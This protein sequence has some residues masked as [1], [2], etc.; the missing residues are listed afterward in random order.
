MAKRA[1]FMILRATV[2][3]ALGGAVWGCSSPSTSPT[4]ENAIAKPMS[5]SYDGP[6]E[7]TVQFSYVGSGG[8]P[9]E[10]AVDPRL[11]LQVANN[12]FTYV[13]IHQNLAGT[14]PALTGQST[15]ATYNATIAPDGTIAGNSGD[16]NGTIQGRV[17]GP[18]MSG[19]IAG[20]MCGYTFTADRI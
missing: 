7:G 2:Y 20:L 17:A 16:L 10:C 13:Q 15:T 5:T 6:Y 14:A 1:N 18:H 3:L 19:Q 8:V 9:S 4:G 11:S 12:S